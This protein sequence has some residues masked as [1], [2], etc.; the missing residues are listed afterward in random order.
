MARPRAQ[1]RGF[2]LVELMVTLVVAA[3][4]AMI[5]V[6]NFRDTLRRSHVSAA[7]NALLA[8]LAYARSEAVSRG[9]YVSLCPSNADG[10]GCQDGLAYEGGWL[11]YTYKPGQGVPNQDYAGDADKEVL[12]RATG[13][14]N[15][16][17]IQAVDAS[18]LSFGPQGQL[19]FPGAGTAPAGL[20][21]VTCYREGAAGLGTS[22]AAVTGVSLTV[23]AS[24]SVSTSPLSPPD[25]ACTASA[26]GTE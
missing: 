8:D 26:P 7:S 15:G 23:R 22:T 1:P 14:R 2:T 19:V 5:A 6:P 18:V 17:S 12:L 4:L 21:F 3:V 16:V 25:S 13:A 9:N 20:D 11:V 10:S 24:G